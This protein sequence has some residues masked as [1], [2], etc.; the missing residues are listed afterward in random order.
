MIDCDIQG[1]GRGQHILN[2]GM[3]F[4]MYKLGIKNSLQCRYMSINAFQIASNSTVY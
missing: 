1:H 3:A 4:I 2:K